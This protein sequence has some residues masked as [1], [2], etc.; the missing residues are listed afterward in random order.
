MD[1]STH[2]LVRERAGHRCEYC[3]LAQS[4]V[5]LATF[6]VEHII[7]KQHGGSDDPGNPA[8]SCHPCNLHKGPN[9]V[10]IDPVTDQICILINPRR[11]AW[12]DHFAMRVFMTQGLTPIG[13]ATARVLAMNSLDQLDARSVA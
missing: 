13:R 2:K 4:A 8:L 5:P 12:L 7:A 3:G 6:H 9:L 11:D 10:G 1:A